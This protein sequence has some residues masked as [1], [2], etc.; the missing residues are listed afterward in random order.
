MRPVQILHFYVRAPNEEM[1]NCGASG[2]VN[3]PFSSVWRHLLFTSRALRYLRGRRDS[4]I[5]SVNYHPNHILLVPYH[6][7]GKYC[8][9]RKRS[10]LEIILALLYRPVI[11]FP[12]QTNTVS[13]GK[14]F[15]PSWQLCPANTLYVIAGWGCSLQSS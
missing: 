8:V 5:D 2:D 14:T 1:A 15:P 12:F 7:F 11:S 9:N 6:W 4:H 10:N 13:K 3:P